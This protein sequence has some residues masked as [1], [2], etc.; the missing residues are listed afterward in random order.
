MKAGIL[1]VAKECN[2][3]TTYRRKKQDRISCLLSWARKTMN[4]LEAAE[5]AGRRIG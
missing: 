5:E 1:I 3:Q 4:L 2:L